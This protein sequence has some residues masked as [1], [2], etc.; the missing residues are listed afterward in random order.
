MALDMCSS[1]YTTKRTPK[2]TGYTETQPQSYP[3]TAKESEQYGAKTVK[4][5]QPTQDGG[6]MT[7]TNKLSE[8]ELTRF[9]EQVNLRNLK[10]KY[11]KIIQHA[12]LTDEAI[13]IKKEIDT[14]E[15]Q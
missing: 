7:Y 10:R 12:D 13:K 8:E 15:S 6:K 1:N 3:R 14:L 2:A 9:R 4:Y 5:K 11:S